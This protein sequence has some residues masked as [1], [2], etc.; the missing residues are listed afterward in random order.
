M[1]IL[2]SEKKA[3]IISH[4]NGSFD[5]EDYTGID[6]STIEKKV[7]Y[8]KAQVIRCEGDFSQKSIAEH[9]Q[10][11]PLT[12][13]YFNDDILELK[14]EWGY[15]TPDKKWLDNYWMAVASLVMQVSK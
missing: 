10:G 3:W 5:Q 7:A 2:P 11:L 15:I 4:I 13:P 1:K 12:I 14:K 8:F 9:L 6:L